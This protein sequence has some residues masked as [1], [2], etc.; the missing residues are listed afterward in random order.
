MYPDECERCNRADVDLYHVSKDGMLYWFIC[1][2]C[3]LLEIDRLA[4]ENADLKSKPASGAI[5]DLPKCVITHGKNFIRV[6]TKLMVYELD[7]ELDGE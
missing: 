1:M 7:A 3:V 5:I 4:S 2:K 6:R